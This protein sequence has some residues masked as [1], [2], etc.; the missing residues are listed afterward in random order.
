VTRPWAWRQVHGRPLLKPKS[1]RFGNNGES[2]DDKIEETHDFTKSDSGLVI[3]A[4]GDDRNTEYGYT[5]F[6]RPISENFINRLKSIKH[7]FTSQND[8]ATPNM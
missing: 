3:L 5:H 4:I 6:R 1:I 2:F 8:I 7:H